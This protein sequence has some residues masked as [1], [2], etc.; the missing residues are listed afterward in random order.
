MSR[1]V[2]ILKDYIVPRKSAIHSCYSDAAAITVA[3]ADGWVEYVN[4]GALYEYKNTTLWDT[5]TNTVN[6]T[7]I[8]S[9]IDI[10]LQSTI[11][12]SANASYLIV[13]LV[14][15]DPDGEIEVAEKTIT[16]HKKG[17][18]VKEPFVFNVYNGEAAN[19]FG[20]KIY[21]MVEGG[22]ITISNRRI[23]IRV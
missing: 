14:I 9:K 15:P 17:V 1:L 23:L 6:D 3:I 8:D 22:D 13:K 18:D 10:V 19:E 21:T 7:I 11:N 2:D 4:N 20:F 12:A 16:I 5:V